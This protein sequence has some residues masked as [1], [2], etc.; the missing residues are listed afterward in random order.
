MESTITADI[1]GRAGIILLL[2]PLPRLQAARERPSNLSV[3]RRQQW[4]DR[5]SRIR[6]RYQRSPAIL[7]AVFDYRQRHAVVCQE[8]GVC[9]S[10]GVTQSHSGSTASGVHV[11]LRIALII[12]VRLCPTARGSF[13]ASMLGHLSNYSTSA[14]HASYVRN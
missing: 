4:C 5:A 3:F 14:V 9:V 6:S 7:H 12:H 8:W 10:W 13:P 11:S 1:T 2:V